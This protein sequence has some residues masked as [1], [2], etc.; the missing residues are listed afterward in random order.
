MIPFADGDV[1]TLFTLRGRSHAMRLEP[2]QGH[3]GTVVEIDVASALRA[4]AAGAVD[5]A[6]VM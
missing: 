1:E 3:E 5:L 2:S 6:I 4:R